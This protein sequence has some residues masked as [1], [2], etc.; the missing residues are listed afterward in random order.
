MENNLLIEKEINFESLNNS[1]QA[2]GGTTAFD[3]V[4]LIIFALNAVIPLLVTAS[5][6]VFL[7]GLTWNIIAK[8]PESKKQA[9]NII[10]YGIIIIFVMISALA[11]VNLLANTVFDQS[12]AQL[13]NNPTQGPGNEKISDFI[14]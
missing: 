12:S 13:R 6:V 3:F 14:R 2:S 1:A 7:W 8:D 5:I 10:I 11:I 9:Q 4:E